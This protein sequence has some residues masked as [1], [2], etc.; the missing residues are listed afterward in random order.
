M[1]NLETLNIRNLPKICRN[2]DGLIG[3]PE[4]QTHEPLAM[5]MTGK[6]PKRSKRIRV[7]GIGCITYRGIWMGRS[8]DFCSN[9]PIDQILSPHTFYAEYPVNVPR[10]EQ[11]TAELAEELS[12]NLRIFEPYWI[13]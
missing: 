11:G 3:V 10:I 4:A 13:D 12:S 6:V 2:E 1:Q 7:M 8:R 9:I 5:L